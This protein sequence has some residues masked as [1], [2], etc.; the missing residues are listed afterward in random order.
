MVALKQPVYPIG[1]VAELLNVHPETI[2]TWER[3]KVVRPP[4][5]RSGKRFY[6]EEDL[7]RLRFI[8]GL[9]EAG[10]N[11]PAIRH[12]LKL[13]PCWF[14]D[15]CPGCVHRS[16]KAVCG[17]P[18][19]KEAGFYCHLSPEAVSR[20]MCRNCE[21]RDRHERCSGVASPEAG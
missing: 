7:Q 17:K 15:G 3:A 19:W 21:Y 20:D 4:Q 1:V 10:L 2:R 6:S 8:Q 13:Y 5:R 16:E 12:Y 14:K 11:L 18:C 9:V